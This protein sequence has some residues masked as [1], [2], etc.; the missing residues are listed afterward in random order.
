MPSIAL[1]SPITS[2]SLAN[3]A[4]SPAIASQLQLFIAYA[5]E[6]HF[7]RAFA[8]QLAAAKGRSYDASADNILVSKSTF[9]TVC[10]HLLCYV[11]VI[12][13]VEALLIIAL[14]LTG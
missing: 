2:S 12:L 8:H 9:K 6:G 13:G 10:L 7:K 14:K 1:V 4:T 11:N 5:V 3:R